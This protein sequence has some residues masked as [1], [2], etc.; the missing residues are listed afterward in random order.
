VAYEPIDTS[1]VERW[2]GKAVGGEQL[3]E[4]VTVS[5]MRRWVQAMH[6]PNPAHYDE[7]HRDTSGKFLAPQSLILACA[8]RHGVT[9]AMQ[10]NIPGGRQMNGGDE[11]WFDHTALQIRLFRVRLCFNAA[12][13]PTSIRTGRFLPGSDRP[14]SAL[15][16]QT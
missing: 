2:M 4:P 14:R 11:W 5:D 6:N 12:K 13:R 16:P 8:V 3:R 7:D 9:P 15:S 10:G 1:D